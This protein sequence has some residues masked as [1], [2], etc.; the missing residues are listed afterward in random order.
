MVEEID[1]RIMAIKDL[2][3]RSPKFTASYLRD[4]R[5][6]P[7]TEAFLMGE[8]EV[9]TKDIW[10]LWGRERVG[11]RAPRVDIYIVEELME[12]EDPEWVARH[13]LEMAE[14]AVEELVCSG[15]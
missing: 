10:R 14:Y 1:R 15:S 8:D 9:D 11:G 12:N 2:L 4:V 7:D 3:N 5:M 6:Y 13:I